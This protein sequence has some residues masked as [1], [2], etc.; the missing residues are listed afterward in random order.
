MAVYL[1]KRPGSIV[2]VTY[3]LRTGGPRDLIPE[4]V[5]F[6]DR[7]HTGHDANRGSCTIGTRFFSGLRKPG[8]KGEHQRNSGAEMEKFLLLCVCWE[9]DWT[10]FNL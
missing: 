8:D 3:P 7:F 5:R 4:R 9:D 2:G 1:T 10:T 6:F